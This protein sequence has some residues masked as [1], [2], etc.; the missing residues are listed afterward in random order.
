MALSS[1]QQQTLLWKGNEIYRAK[2]SEQEGSGVFGLLSEE[3]PWKGRVPG[4]APCSH[5]PIFYSS[6]VTLRISLSTMGWVVAPHLTVECELTHPLTSTRYLKVTYSSKLSSFTLN[7]RHL[8]L[9]VKASLR[10]NPCEQSPNPSFSVLG[11]SVLGSLPLDFL[12]SL[13]VKTEMPNNRCC[14][15]SASVQIHDP[16]SSRVKQLGLLKA[17]VPELPPTWLWGA[18]R[19]VP[20]G[21]GSWIM[22]SSLLPAQPRLH[23]ESVP[24]CKASFTAEHPPREGKH[25]QH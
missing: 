7:L 17:P 15:C 20:G 9:S 25:Q 22:G 19:V 11:N 4:P 5:L 1:C 3:S 8:Q 2:P 6:L 14:S 21:G 16:E 13:Q 24:A 12:L 23:R 18:L 10:L